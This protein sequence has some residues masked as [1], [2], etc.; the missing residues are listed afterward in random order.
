NRLAHVNIRTVQAAIKDI[1]NVDSIEVDEFFCEGCA[2][3]KNHRLP[4]KKDDKK[5][6]ELPGE[7]IHA[8]VCG[9]MSTPSVGKSRYLLMF[10][11]DA[12]NYT[13]AYFLKEKSETA[14]VF[15]QFVNEFYIDSGFKVKRIRT[16]NG[17]EFVNQ[18]FK[19]TTDE[20]GIVHETTVAYSPEQNGAIERHNRTIIESARSMIHAKGLPLTLWAE[21]VSCAIYTINRLP[22]KTIGNISPYEK[23]FNKKPDLNQMR[24]FGSEVFVHIP[25]L[26]RSKLDSKSEKQLFVGYDEKKKAIRVYDS[27]RNSVSVVRDVIFPKMHPYNET[28]E[29]DRNSVDQATTKIS[30]IVLNDEE[31]PEENIETKETEV[32]QNRYNLRPR[33]DKQHY[34]CI[35]DDEPS[36]FKEAL[37]SPE[38][39]KW[40]E[41]IEEELKSLKANNTWIDVTRPK[42]RKVISNKWVFKRKIKPDG[43]I[44]RYKARLVVK[45]FNQQLGVDYTETFSPVVR[46]T[47]VRVILSLAV[48][49]KMN[50]VHFD[51][52]TA[53]LY[54]DLEEEIYMEKPEG[55]N[56]QHDSVCKLLKSLYGL[57]QAPRQWKKKFDY[58]L[59]RFNLEQSKAD[60]CV[61]SMRNGNSMLIIAIYVDDGLACSNNVKLLS[62]VLLFIE[63]QFEIT[64]SN[65]SCFVGIEIES[66]KNRNIVRIHQE[67]Y[68]KKILK[69]FGLE[70]C[71][72]LSIPSDPHIK[73]CKKM[74]TNVDNEEE[75]HYPFRE[76]IGS[77][78]YLMV[79]TR[80]DIAFAV[81]TLSQYLDKATKQHWNAAIRIL[82]YIKGSL[83]YGITFSGNE[84]TIFGYCDADYANDID[85]RRSTSGCVIMM[86]GGAV[87]WL[88]QKQRSVALSTTESEYISACTSA[89]E[90][91]WL[92]QLLLDLSFNVEKPIDLYC[93]N[94]SAIKLI[95]NPEFHKRTK[96]IDVQ[97][98][99]VREKY[100][101]RIIDVKFVDTNDQLADILTKPLASA[102]F[103]RLRSMIGLHSKSDNDFVEW[104]C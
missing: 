91:V 6:A 1:T 41:A 42:D 8:D 29:A 18:F 54:G 3:G 81:S 73:I 37:L 26:F 80:P 49:M 55:Y 30:T 57:K 76:L 94:M 22:S 77:L 63:K 88:S 14:M 46:F 62:E 85:T 34:A 43:S 27:K 75:M 40:K 90:I 9:P 7:L 36:T 82:R 20:Y 79:A 25:K 93:D 45:G 28:L 56:T 86:N 39:N 17:I 38:A 5:R 83:N 16:D 23:I 15:K 61:Y 69:R 74:S 92:R 33:K 96:H 99:F 100:E 84:N 4:F 50:I 97:Y 65:A 24:V 31:K 21:A 60:P 102:V 58:F 71:K 95:R 66:V 87:S 10:K 101:Q 11:D 72:P 2:Y 51:V 12:T 98:H 78:M 32:T 64:K 70:E 13:M 47:S 53:F 68:A 48:S 35:A 59:K 19:E 103:L 44:E 52:K 104:E 89:K 67:G